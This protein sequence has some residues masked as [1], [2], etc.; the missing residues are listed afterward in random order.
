[1]GLDG[2]IAGQTDGH[3]YPI[4]IFTTGIGP[5][6]NNNWNDYHVIVNLIIPVYSYYKVR[7]LSLHFMIFVF[8]NIKQ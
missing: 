7:T 4:T 6:V 2:W 5:V 8:I 1:M 3:T